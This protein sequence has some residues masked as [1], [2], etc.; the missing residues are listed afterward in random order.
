VVEVA[1]AEQQLS[2][3]DGGPDEPGAVVLP[4]EV[5]PVGVR[6]VDG[7]GPRYRSTAAR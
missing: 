6:D 2:G 5:D 7:S 4:V 1:A 3:T